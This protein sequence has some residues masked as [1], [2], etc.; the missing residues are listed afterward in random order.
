[1]I[2]LK[3]L[4]ATIPIEINIDKSFKNIRKLFLNFEKTNKSFTQFKIHIFKSNNRLI[5]LSKDYKELEISGNNINDLENPFNIIGILQAIFRFSAIHS[6]KKNIYL[7]HGSAAIL[8]NKTFCFGDDG[9]STAKTLSSVECALNSK[10]YIG[11]EFCFLDINTKKIFSYSFIPLHLRPDVKRHFVQT[12]K[13][14][15]PYSNYKETESGYFIKPTKLFKVITSSTL[16]SFVF[17]HLNNKCLKLK[18]L[19]NRQKKDSIGICISAH[20]LKLFYPLKK[21]D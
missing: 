19:N 12:H 5:K 7:L 9:K 8:N 17:I 21:M 13:I 2:N 10:K 18:S 15:F 6:I 3:I 16:N 1:M 11:D 14:I 4:I 20:L